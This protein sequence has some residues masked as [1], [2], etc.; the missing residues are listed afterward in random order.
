MFCWK[1][2]QILILLLWDFLRIGKNN[3]CGNL[4]TIKRVMLFCCCDIFY[5]ARSRSFMDISV[6]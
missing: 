2:I 6:S 1:N 5:L 3:L 4:K